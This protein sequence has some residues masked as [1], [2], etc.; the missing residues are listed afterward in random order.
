MTLH[1]LQCRG[2]QLIWQ[3]VH[4]TAKN[5]IG[6]GTKPPFNSFKNICHDQVRYIYYFMISK[7][8]RL[9][10]MYRLGMY[11]SFNATWSGTGQGRLLYLRFDLLQ[12]IAKHG[13]IVMAWQRWQ[14]HFQGCGVF[15]VTAKSRQSLESS[16]SI[17]LFIGFLHGHVFDK[18]LFQQSGM[19]LFLIKHTYTLYRDAAP[20]KNLWGSIVMWW[21]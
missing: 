10:S 12:R 9:S 14:Q 13:E 18:Q 8:Y 1:D 7:L 4:C 20:F 17:S 11:S 16:L 2:L 6:T 5:E 3:G 21:G 15:K 19:C